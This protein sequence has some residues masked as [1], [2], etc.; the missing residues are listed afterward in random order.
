MANNSFALKLRDTENREVHVIVHNIVFMRQVPP[1]KDAVGFTEIHVVGQQK[2][3]QVHDK[4]EEIIKRAKIYSGV[5]TE[6][7]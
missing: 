5:L 7:V 3:F 6:I 2:P 4:V 1:I